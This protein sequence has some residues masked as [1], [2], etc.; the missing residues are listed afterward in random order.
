MRPVT[1]G[2]WIVGILIVGP[3]ILVQLILVIL[4]VQV[5]TEQAQLYVREGH[6]FI[7]YWARSRAAMILVRALLMLGLF[8]LF[9]AAV[10]GTGTDA[11]TSR[12]R[13]MVAL[14]AFAGWLCLLVFDLLPCGPS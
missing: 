11:L 7:E 6:G 5:G 8:C 3:M 1:G 13:G 9:V 4:I 12:A 2:R 14:F 10:F